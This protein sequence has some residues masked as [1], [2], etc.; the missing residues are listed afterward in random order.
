MPWLD[1]NARTRSLVQLFPLLVRFPNR[2]SSPA[3]S[4]SDKLRASS[5]TSSMVPASVVQRCCPVRWRTTSSSLWSPPFQCSS[6]RIRSPSIVAVISTSAARRTALRSPGVAR[7]CSQACSRSSPRA[8]YASRSCGVTAVRCR[9][10]ASASSRSSQARTSTRHC[11][12]LLAR[13]GG[14]AGPGWPSNE[15]EASG[16][17]AGCLRHT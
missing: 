3:V 16:L 5:R 4:G 11:S 6:K 10:A 2:F 15:P 8:R 13:P 17:R 1:R 7:S 9:S 12:H 14:P